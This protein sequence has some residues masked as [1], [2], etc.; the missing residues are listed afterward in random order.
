MKSHTRILLTLSVLAAAAITCGRGGNAAPTAGDGP[1][2]PQATYTS[3]PTPLPLVSTP[4]ELPGNSDLQ[5]LIAYANAVL[6]LM[7]QAGIL[8]ERDGVILESAQDGNDNVLCDGRLAADNSAMKNI[9]ANLRTIQPP[10]KAD[11][12]HDLLLKSGD[13]WTDALDDVE[14]FCSTGNALYEVS[15]VAKFWQ[16]AFHF[17]DAGN[18]FWLL[19]VSQGI[20]AWVQR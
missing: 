11:R 14:S 7:N 9:V 5:S 6:P 4:A 19:V 8:L 20:D 18:R 12:I 10:S 17:Q 1:S 16:A 3:V 2:Q 13:S 15:A